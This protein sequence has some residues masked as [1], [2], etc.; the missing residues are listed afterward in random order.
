MDY[1]MAAMNILYR[2]VN[3]PPL[4]HIHTSHSPSNVCLLLLWVHPSH[5]PPRMTA[6]TKATQFL[7]RTRWSCAACSAVNSES[8][9]SSY[10]LRWAYLHRQ[11]VYSFNLSS[12]SGV[13]N[14]YTLIL[15][16]TDTLTLTLRIHVLKSA[17]SLRG[18]VFFFFI[19]FFFLFVALKDLMITFWLLHSNYL[20]PCQNKCKAD[21][22]PPS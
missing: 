2:S 5:I 19:Y 6:L 18:Q 12:T 4:R 7:T 15:V 11:H 17:L 8:F 10:P 21:S 3:P 13:K 9:G 1:P 22:P 14:D 20:T 16:L